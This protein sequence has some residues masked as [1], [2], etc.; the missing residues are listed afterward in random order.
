MK[1][2]QPCLITDVGLNLVTEEQPDQTIPSRLHHQHTV[3]QGVLPIF[4]PI[5]QNLF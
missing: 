1:L 3:H 2:R 4:Q 5:R